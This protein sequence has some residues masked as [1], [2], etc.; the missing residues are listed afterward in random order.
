MPYNKKN[1]PADPINKL[2]IQRNFFL[3]RMDMAA[4]A[5]AI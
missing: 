2:P 3:E 4:I 1:N 5:M